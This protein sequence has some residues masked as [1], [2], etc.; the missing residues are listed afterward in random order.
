MNLFSAIGKGIA[1]LINDTHA[2]RQRQKAGE[3][4]F[5]RVGKKMKKARKNHKRI[6]GSKMYRMEYQ[7][8]LRRIQAQ[9]DRNEQFISDL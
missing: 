9:H 7:K 6:N 5:N 3:V 8:E 1:R 2:E 4:A